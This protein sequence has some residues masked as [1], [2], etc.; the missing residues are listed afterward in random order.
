MENLTQQNDIY[1]L[2]GRMDGKM[3]SITTILSHTSARVDNME[4]RL[5]AVERGVT[6]QA[7][8]TSNNKNWMNYL[9][10]FGAV[11]VSIWTALTGGML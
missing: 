6:T 9:A 4:Q 3:D 10:S 11:V 8:S 1:L 7:A 2:L 5:S